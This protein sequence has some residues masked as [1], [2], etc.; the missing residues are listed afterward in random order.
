MGCSGCHTVGEEYAHFTDGN[1]YDTGIGYAHSM[2]IG[3]E[4]VPV[5]LA[6]GVEVTPTVVLP[7]PASNDLGRYEATGKS[8]DRWLYRVPTLRN[9]AITG[10]YM[11]NGTLA[12][13]DAVIDYYDRGGVPHEGLDPRIRPLGLDAG[14][15]SDLVAFLHSLTGSNVAA[16]ARDGRGQE[17]GNAR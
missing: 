13:L 8:A 7:A 4:T 3:T 9:V 6:P 1:F 10:P 2:A 11:H 16:L 12:D 17:I 5:R 14:E 15:N